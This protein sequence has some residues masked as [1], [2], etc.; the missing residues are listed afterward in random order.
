MSE[1]NFIIDTGADQD[2]STPHN[3]GQDNII[4]IPL[5]SGDLEM[6]A[7]SAAFDRI[8]SLQAEA[9]FQPDGRSGRAD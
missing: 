3:F 1:S 2:V 5:S 9:I 7:A 8:L 4:I 6:S